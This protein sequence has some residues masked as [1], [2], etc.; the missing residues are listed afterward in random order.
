MVWRKEDLETPSRWSRAGPSPS[1]TPGSRPGQSPTGP[2]VSGRQPEDL[3]KGPRLIGRPETKRQTPLKGSRLQ[4]GQEERR[5]LPRRFTQLLGKAQAPGSGSHLQHR[6]S[7]E[8]V[9]DAALGREGEKL[10][11]WSCNR[12]QPTSRSDSQLCRTNEKTRQRR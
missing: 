1:L 11:D 4:A 7:K 8:T 2:S 5:K 3:T 9:R 12:R 6:R 10:T